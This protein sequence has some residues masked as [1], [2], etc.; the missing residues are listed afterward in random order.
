MR[1]ELFRCIIYVI[2][3]FM[4]DERPGLA[5][6][7]LHSGPARLARSPYLIFRAGQAR[8]AGPMGR[9]ARAGLWRRP[10][11]P[12]HGL[13]FRVW[14]IWTSYTAAWIF[15]PW[16]HGPHFRRCGICKLCIYSSLFCHLGLSLLTENNRV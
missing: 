14:T 3:N 1:S 9:P 4:A 12:Y 15:V 10:L 16:A 2:S 6:P 8:L 11:H 5:R 7:V 13:Y